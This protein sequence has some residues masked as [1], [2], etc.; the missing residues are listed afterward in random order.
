MTGPGR[1]DD[2]VSGAQLDDFAAIAAEPDARVPA[3]NTEHFVGA[4][5]IVQEVINAVAPRIRPTIGFEKVLE[6]RRRVLRLREAHR[7]AVVNKG[8]PRIVGYRT[9]VLK[10]D[11]MGL[12][13]T[14]EPA[15]GGG[16]VLA[17]AGNLL[18]GLF[19]CFEDVQA[20]S[21][22]QFPLKPRSDARLWL[23]FS[24][25]RVTADGHASS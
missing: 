18:E 14:N 25:S 23:A 1:Q 22:R 4:R 9:V 2:D 15:H 8:Q 24:A 16:G 13:A 21:L 12:A 10:H 7:A 11:G 3:R 20:L 17:G 5:M 19:Q 6:D